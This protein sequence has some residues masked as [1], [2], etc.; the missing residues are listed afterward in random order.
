[1]NIG[2]G[3]FLISLLTLIIYPLSY[4]A[5]TATQTV[6]VIILICRNLLILA[7][8]WWLIK[9]LITKPTTN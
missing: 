3:W 6:M 5:L 7:W 2:I 9:E 4:G 1:M 8:W